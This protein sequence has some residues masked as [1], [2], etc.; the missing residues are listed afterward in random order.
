M[1]S[2]SSFIVVFSS[3]DRLAIKLILI[4]IHAKLRLM[5]LRKSAV[6]NGIFHL[7][8]AVLLLLRALHTLTVHTR[9]VKSEA[10]LL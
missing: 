7:I 8:L 10:K 2:L 1:I 5:L 4:A 9:T 6:K 3:I